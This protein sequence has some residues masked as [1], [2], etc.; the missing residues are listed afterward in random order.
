MKHAR[1]WKLS[2][3]QRTDLWNPWKPG[4][5]PEYSTAFTGPRAFCLVE[6]LYFIRQNPDPSREKLH[7]MFEEALGKHVV[8]KRVN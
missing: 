3:A 2:A 8:L 5:S 6:S 1:R 4:R 7:Q